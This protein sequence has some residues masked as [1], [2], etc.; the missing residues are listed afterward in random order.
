MKMKIKNA[1]VTLACTGVLALAGCK[2][3]PR[4]AMFPYRECFGCKGEQAYSSQE[5]ILWKSRGYQ[6][7][8][9]NQL[10]EWE[11]AEM[12]S[13]KEFAEHEYKSKYGVPF[14]HN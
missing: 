10:T 4:E 7:P 1:L 14:K 2:D 3:K 13:C 8:G 5:V 12:N 6:L 11:L 9:V